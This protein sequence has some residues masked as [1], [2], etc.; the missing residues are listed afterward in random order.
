MWERGMLKNRKLARAIAEIG[1]SKFRSMLDYK[2][3]IYGCILVVADRF[4]PSSKLCSS[5]GNIKE[6]LALSER[7]YSCDKCDLEIDR[8]FNAAL[9]LKQYPR[10][11]G[12]WRISRKKPEE[13][14]TSAKRSVSLIVDPGTFNTLIMAPS[15]TLLCIE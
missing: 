10:L 15:A 9:N 14:K 7:I 12:N 3:K 6:K 4:F 5:C 2:C 1:F 13:I 8:D 11:S